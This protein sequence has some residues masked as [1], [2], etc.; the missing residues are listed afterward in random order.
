MDVVGGDGLHPCLGAAGRM[1]AA[2]SPGLPH[3]A[4]VARREALDHLLQVVGLRVDHLLQHIGRY[5]VAVEEVGVDVLRPSDGAAGHELRIGAEI[6]RA[7][8]AIGEE[9]V[10]HGAEVVLRLRIAVAVAHAREV[11][12]LDVRH[13][14]GGAAYL[15]LIGGIGLRIARVGGAARRRNEREA[16]VAAAT[17]GDQGG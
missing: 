12:G 11:V 4:V 6:L 3:I 14:H 1:R 17:A 5:H 10:G 15:G 9:R 7:L 16:V 2:A 8:A 13:A